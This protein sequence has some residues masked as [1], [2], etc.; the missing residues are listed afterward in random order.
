MKEIHGYQIEI[1][2]NS[3]FKNPVK[4]TVGKTKTKYTLKNQ[5]AGMKYYI[6]IRAYRKYTAEDGTSKKIFGKWISVNI[7]K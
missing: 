7:K 1:S 5:K 3:N 2:T 4:I 6:R